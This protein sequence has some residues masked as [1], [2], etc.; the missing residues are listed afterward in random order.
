[1]KRL[2][3]LQWVPCDS[4][5]DAEARTSERKLIGTLLTSD[6]NTWGYVETSEGWCLRVGYANLGLVPQAIAVDQSMLVG[7]DE[8]LVGYDLSTGSTSFTYR[9][10][11]VFHEFVK[12]DDPLLVRD[13]MGFVSITMD[14]NELWKSSAPGVI[15]SYSV[16]SNQNSGKTTDG[17]N[18]LFDIPP[19]T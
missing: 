6:A 17:T 7:I 11:W 4:R 18:F 19:A 8:V 5:N 1:M 12:I 16:T 14:G 9:M 10:P 2:E 15:E 3:I 13:E